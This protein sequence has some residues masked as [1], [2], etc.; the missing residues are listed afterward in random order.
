MAGADPFKTGNTAFRLGLGKVLVP[1]VFV[2]HPP[3]ILEGSILEI[4]T[5]VLTASVGVGL[6]GIG[7]A[8]YLFRPLGWL[9]R[10]WAIA[11]ATL[12]I[13]P[14]QTLVPVVVL[15]VAGFGLGLALVISERLA[16]AAHT[17]ATAPRRVP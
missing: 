3:L 2:Y 9:R 10:G 15:D 13:L 6:L 8:G 16:G 17:V 14:P 5:T 1:F 4:V 12:L 11:A 7:C